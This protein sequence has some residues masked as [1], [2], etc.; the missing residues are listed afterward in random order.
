MR[1]LF[2][3][4]KTWSKTRITIIF[5]KS[6]IEM[7]RIVRSENV[8][9]DIYPD[10]TNVIFNQI[11][12]LYST[13]WLSFP[14]L[15]LSSGM[16]DREYCPSLLTWINYKELGSIST[17]NPIKVR[18]HLLAKIGLFPFSGS[19]QHP[20][21]ELVNIFIYSINIM[22]SFCTKKAQPW[23]LSFSHLHSIIYCQ[24]NFFKTF[25]L[26]SQFHPF[27]IEDWIMLTLFHPN[28]L[29]WFYFFLI[30]LSEFYLV[31]G[32]RGQ[33]RVWCKILIELY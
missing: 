26:D 8:T 21:K 31:N 5:Y 17:T 18:N 32:F 25:R 23:R 7:K 4:K 28:L 12:I 9:C 20:T 11:F 30:F 22:S 2:I 19:F 24:I 3:L 15:I 6:N 29:N 13:Y 27:S 10:W 14:L 16:T 33:S 1:I